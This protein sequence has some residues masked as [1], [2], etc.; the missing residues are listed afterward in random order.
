MAPDL[1]RRL[2]RSLAF[3]VVETELT[4]KFIEGDTEAWEVE[5]DEARELIREAGFDIDALYP[6][7][8]RPTAFE[9]LPGGLH[10]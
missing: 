9:V 6:P 2:C 4:V 5:C 10:G 1:I 3:H 7:E 8:D